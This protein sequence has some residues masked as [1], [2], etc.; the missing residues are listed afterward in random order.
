MP[1]ANHIT[2]GQA[3]AA[4]KF[5]QLPY[6]DHEHYTGQI[7][8]PGELDVKARD[9]D[10]DHF[11]TMINKVTKLAG[12]FAA[13]NAGVA[14]ILN[15]TPRF[16]SED[17]TYLRYWFSALLCC[18]MYGTEG[19]NDIHIGNDPLLL[20][21]H[22]RKFLEI[23]K[24]KFDG[25]GVGR[26]SNDGTVASKG[27][28]VEPGCQT[29]SYNYITLDPMPGAGKPQLG[30]HNKVGTFHDQLFVLPL[31]EYKLGGIPGAVPE[32][33][34]KYFYLAEGA[35]DKEPNIQPTDSRIWEKYFERLD[36]L[37]VKQKIMILVSALSIPENAPQPL[38]LAKA[39][40]NELIKLPDEVELPPVDVICAAKTIAGIDF[41]KTADFI[42]LDSMISDT[43]YIGKQNEKFYATYPLT[44][45][46]VKFIKD[47]T[48]A[49]PNKIK[50]SLTVNTKH[51]DPKTVISADLT[52]SVNTTLRFIATP[53]NNNYDHTFDYS[54]ERHYFADENAENKINWIRA[55]PTICMYPN[56]KSSHEHR[57]SRFTYFSR[58]GATIL[59]QDIKGIGT[60]IR[61][62]DGSLMGDLDGTGIRN[63]LIN[64]A[65]GAPAPYTNIKA[66]D[67]GI[68]ISTTT[69][70]KPEH[71]IMLSN[72]GG[73]V[74]YGYILNIKS[75]AGGDLPALLE[76]GATPVEIVIDRKN[77]AAPNTLSA[78]IDFGSSS[79]YVRYSVNG[80][81]YNTD[82]VKNRCTLRTCLAGYNMVNYEILINDPV[83][84]SRHKFLSTSSVYNPENP[85]ISNYNPYI[86][87]WMPIV[88]SYTD[89]PGIRNIFTSHKTDIVAGGEGPDYARII[90]ENILYTVACNAIENECTVVNIVT[91]LPSKDYESGLNTKWDSAKRD[92]NKIF[93]GL[94][95][96]MFLS[97]TNNHFLY[98]SIAIALGQPGLAN[99]TMIVNIDM[100][101]GTTDLSAIYVD[102]QTTI[103]LCGYSSIEY[104]GKDLI[105]TVVKDI[106]QQPEE[107][108]DKLM[109]GS[110]D[111]ISTYGRPIF[112]PHK[113][114]ENVYLEFV[115]AL[116]TN[117]RDNNNNT[118]YFESKV[119]DILEV[120]S[121]GGGEADKDQKIAA[122][123]ILRYMIFMPLV[124][125]FIHTAIKIAG[126]IYDPANAAIQINFR[127]GAAKGFGLFDGLDHLRGGAALQLLTNYFVK[128][129]Q[130]NLATTV[131]VNT[132]PGDDKQAL[133]DGLK[134]INSIGTE[135]KIVGHNVN[136]VDWDGKINP[137][138]T[139]VFGYQNNI[140]KN[141]FGKKEAEFVFHVVPGTNTPD[142]TRCKKDNDTIIKR[143]STYYEDARNPF[144]DFKK[145]YFDEIYSKLIDNDD[146]N[147][148]VIEMLTYDLLE[149][150]SQTMSAAIRSELTT[151]SSFVKATTSCIYPEMMKSAIFMFTLSKILSDFHGTY[152]ADHKIT[153]T[154]DE[155][156]YKFGTA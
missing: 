45:A 41:Y 121:F 80:G 34:K 54:K 104:A 151:G 119:M 133:I 75:V 91:S 116:K 15:I 86:H 39:L 98:E 152:R 9:G 141:A 139:G 140:H 40:I 96:S 10:S 117:K 62:N 108:F 149:N 147:P 11:V 129:F 112:E 49:E 113:D 22:N 38:L 142:I 63:K 37:N 155:T 124:K 103:N 82:L 51:D 50:M 138:H 12:E 33:K 111:G 84:N 67:D 90:I 115:R 101:D 74:S 29:A 145:F 69:A 93:G 59:P 32:W 27:A 5:L 21:G 71:F 99:D 118:D 16:V 60:A 28:A 123:F 122:N 100:G 24:H 30:Y 105:K 154:G 127:G 110:L 102:A 85:G 78:Y 137:K 64:F 18:M 26:N 92:I 109:I 146:G 95:Y 57:C 44:E 17:G 47:G 89:Y 107:I 131:T 130:G 23:W 153:R 72:S 14:A 136:G 73:V 148:D 35:T 125:D 56:L 128:E 68:D 2:A 120:A 144:A 36:S 48:T 55:V 77:E 134:T 66:Y 58:K 42:D 1:V 88:G 79:S 65:A 135:L 4:D 20:A 46:G 87:G 8:G 97:C 76:S 126:G 25:V 81:Q 156:G 52:F 7:K 143:T 70:A 114:K 150:P 106:L 43:L 13:P 31:K 6:N 61:L 3:L 53:G 19:S 94:N 132:T 83:K